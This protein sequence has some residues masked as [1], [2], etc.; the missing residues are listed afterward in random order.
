MQNFEE[1]SLQASAAKQENAI[2][3]SGMT[4][5][6]TPDGLAAIAINDHKDYAY[7]TYASASDINYSAEAFFR[8]GQDMVK[9]LKNHITNLQYASQLRQ[10]VWLR[11]IAE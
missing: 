3:A 6:D 1:D 8:H 9:V 11:D 10:E 5:S 2:N 4:N 7:K